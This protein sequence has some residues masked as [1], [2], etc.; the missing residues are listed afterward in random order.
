MRRGRL[1]EAVIGFWELEARFDLETSAELCRQLSNMLLRDKS[2][3][4]GF[5]FLDRWRGR[6]A[7][8]IHG[9]EL[10]IRVA[11][12]E[13]VS[14]AYY[15]STLQ[16]EELLESYRGKFAGRRGAWFLDWAESLLHSE[17]HEH[18]KAASLMRRALQGAEEG[19][20]ATDRFSLAV[21]LAE[22]LVVLNRMEEGRPA[23]DRA[24]EL[25]E[26]TGR[27]EHLRY[28]H[29]SL[30]LYHLGLEEYGRAEE[31]F[32]RSLRIAREEGAW[33]EPTAAR[34]NLA[35]ALF[36][37]GEYG[38]MEPVVAEIERACANSERLA[39]VL[40]ERNLLALIHTGC[41][42]LEAARRHLEE[43]LPVARETGAR[44]MEGLLLDKR[45]RLRNLMG[46]GE[47]AREDHRA[48]RAAFEEIGQ[49]DRAEL[50]RLREIETEPGSG[51]EHLDAA[52]A[53]FRGP[54]FG[55]ER[56]LALRLRALRRRRAGDRDGAAA[57]LREAFETARRIGN[58]E[59]L[60]PLHAEAAELAL[61]AGDGKGARRELG[62]ALEILRRLAGSFSDAEAGRLYLARP[63]RRAC[64]DRLSAL[65]ES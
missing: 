53:R 47:G 44:R 46:D 51:A 21:Q 24:R 22:F 7:G 23:L 50:L 38:R 31:H 11:A 5:A 16:A 36:Q 37:Q 41:G 56:I 19:A 14:Y 28:V 29:N 8:E 58:P 12:R 30:G 43:S 48:A 33:R 10:E 34:N 60:W 57:D 42:N 54:G 9:T 59:G 26:E 25:A 49:P 3:E 32:R 64:L 52:L 20:A 13:V 65:A 4:E 40:S 15:G 61:S 27:P 55:Q 63:D 6:R 17:R 2:V 35:L 18:E 39:D 62:R 45:G 1:P